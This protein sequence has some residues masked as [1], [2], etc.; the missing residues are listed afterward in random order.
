M[1]EVTIVREFLA[2]RAVFKTHGWSVAVGNS[3]QLRSPE[4]VCFE[5]GTLDGLTAAALMLE[6]LMADVCK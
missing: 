2:L 3:F 6:H 1:D 4:G 5:I